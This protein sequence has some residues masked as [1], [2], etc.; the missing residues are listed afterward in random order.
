MRRRDLLIGLVIAMLAVQTA[1]SRTKSTSSG[2]STPTPKTNTTTKTPKTDT[3]TP[4]PQ[5]G[6]ATSTSTTG[7][8]PRPTNV[9]RFDAETMKAALHTASPEDNG[10]IDRILN[11]VRRGALSA[12]LVD[13]TFVWAKHKP[14]Y[15]FQYFK[16]GLIHRANELGIR[17]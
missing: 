10:F 3:T 11:K 12:D 17:L 14:R 9:P 16:Y 2:T 6:T 1:V 13:T 7:C 15:R 4:L 5:T 8:I